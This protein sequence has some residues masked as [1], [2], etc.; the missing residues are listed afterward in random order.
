M[1]VA[2]LVNDGN[3]VQ[4]YEG[5]FICLDQMFEDAIE[6]LKPYNNPAA[7]QYLK[8]VQQLVS[9]R[10]QEIFNGK[11]ALIGPDIEFKDTRASAR[12]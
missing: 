2:T 11:K 4:C 9:A 3:S 1:R 7:V 8:L 6:I 10:R 5:D 12:A